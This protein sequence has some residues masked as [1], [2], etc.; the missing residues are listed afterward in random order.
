[1]TA[2][3]PLSV[4][5]SLFHYN[6]VT[7]AITYIVQRGPHKF[8]DPAGGNRDGIPH[9]FVDGRQRKAAAV[10]WAL[11][12]RVDPAPQHVACR[13]GDPFNLRL[14]NLYLSDSRPDYKRFSG[15]PGKRPGWH[16]RDLSRDRVTGDWNAKYDG[17][18]LGVFGTKAEAVSA[19]R[20]AALEDSDDA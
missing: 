6:R 3:P 17:V 2:L 5:Q 19:R 15:R 18:E 4:L 20:L 8:G 7:G 1:M 13:D 12:Y 9:V 16:R 11:A 14:D 10:A